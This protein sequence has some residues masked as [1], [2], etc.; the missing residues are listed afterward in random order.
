LLGKDAP[1]LSPT[2]I[3]RLKDGWYQRKIG[4]CLRYTGRGA[5]AL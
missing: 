1:G 5:D 4:S 2:A 3:G